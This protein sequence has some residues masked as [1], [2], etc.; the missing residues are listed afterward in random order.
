VT[1]ACVTNAS[2]EKFTEPVFDAVLTDAPCSGEGMFRRGEGA[3]E[4]WTPDA[5][6]ICAHRQ[7][8]I[9]DCAARVLKPG[10]RLVYSTCTFNRQENEF[11][12]ARFLELHPE[13]EP[14]DFE[15]EGVGA[16]EN[17]CLRL[18][19]HKLNGE[20]HFVC[21]L[22]K[23]GAPEER[24]FS[25][26]RPSKEASD[27]L[28]MLIKT[29]PCRLPEGHAE[30]INGELWLVPKCL[31][32]LKGVYTLSKGLALGRAGK[33]FFEPAHQLAMALS[34]ETC[35]RSAELSDK[36]AA[37]YMQGEAL[38][39]DGEDGWTLVTWRGLPLGWGK[40]SQGTLKNHLPKG[41]R[42]RGGH[43]IKA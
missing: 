27:A 10:G 39:L 24:R 41:L 34:P 5:P 2:P 13:F 33:G 15:L 4:E 36:D 12:I 1:N 6:E 32:E 43:S 9:L 20:G 14:W 40:R 23:K 19:P 37:L 26:A 21:R 28:D 22:I 17:G 31:P 35:A 25:S 8:K 7:E 18:W 16:S 30:I 3:L 29:V 42:L 38:S 11:G